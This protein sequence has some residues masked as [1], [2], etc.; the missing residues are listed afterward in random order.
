MYV[1]V[2]VGV[3]PRMHA[4]TCVFINKEETYRYKKLLLNGD[5]VKGFPEPAF[6]QVPKH[7]GALAHQEALE[8]IIR[9]QCV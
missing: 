8:Y 7:A 9:C 3:Y 2:H 5:D 6:T 4:H 1:Y